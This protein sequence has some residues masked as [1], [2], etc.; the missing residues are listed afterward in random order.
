MGLASAHVLPQL[1]SLCQFS[2]VHGSDK[3][4]QHTTRSVFV[5]LYGVPTNAAQLG[6]VNMCV[7]SKESITRPFT[8]ILSPVSASGKYFLIKSA[9]AFHLCPLQED[10]PSH[11]YPS[12][13][14]PH[15]TDFPK[16]PQVSTSISY[17]ENSLF[18]SVNHF[19]LGCFLDI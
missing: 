12:K 2:Q 16:N 9:L 6:N 3:K 1:A 11:V 7:V 14:P 4:L 15:T 17:V 19:S 10:D 18:R 13:T 8:C 5:S